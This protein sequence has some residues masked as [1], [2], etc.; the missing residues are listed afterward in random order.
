MCAWAAGDTLGVPQ[1]VQD[2]ITRRVARLPEHCR[3]RTAGRGADRPRL[4]A[5]AA[6]A[7]DR[8]RP[9][10]LLDVLDAA[11]RGALLVEVPSAPGRYSFAHALLRSTMEAAV[12]L[13]PARCPAPTDRRGDRAV[14][15]RPS[16]R[17]CSPF[18]RSRARSGRPRRATTP[19]ARQARPR[20][21]SPTTTRWSCWSGR[22]PCA[23]R[24]TRST[25]LEV[26]R[27]E[28]ALG[29]AQAGAGR[30]EAARE[31]FARAAEAARAAAR[32]RPRQ[33][34]SSR[35]PRSATPA[36]SG[37]STADT[38][39][40]VSHSSRRR[41]TDCRPETPTAV[42]GARAARRAALLGTSVSWEQQ[43][44][45]ADTAVDIARR[46]GDD[47]ALVAALAA[48]QHARWRPGPQD[49]RLS[50][51][52]ELIDLTEP[53]MRWW[54]Q[55]WP[56]SAERAC[57]SSDARW[58]MP[59]THLDRFGEIAERIQQYQLLMFRGGM[60][61]MRPCWWATTELGRRR[62]RRCSTGA[63]A[64]SGTTAR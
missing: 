20:T 18:R 12:S 31:T 55:P 46:L 13:D 4:R 36:A 52:D 64:L 14:L 7:G 25:K 62:P 43:H 30:W 22:W 54:R 6:R 41:S 42:A 37:S 50:I 35:A 58:R 9:D 28:T 11:V 53:R 51:I 19:S 26:A 60:R 3:P 15:P 10:T 5:R 24:T 57:C 45:V 47:D 16:R 44:D 56:T 63:G 59:S 38:T 2:V 27:L 33:A 17:S 48:A 32:R 49:D 29:T 61:A 34:H 39:P 21:G 23:N 1:G 8:R 40:P